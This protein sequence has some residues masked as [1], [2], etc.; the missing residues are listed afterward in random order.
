MVSVLRVKRIAD[1]IQEE[2]AEMLLHEVHDP[3]LA[4]V[5]VTSVN[6]DRELAF[7]DIFVSSLE[8][9][10]RA[11]EILAGFER[12]SGFLRKELSRRVELR[13]FPILRFHYDTTPEKAERIEQLLR[14]LH[15]SA[16]TPVN[17]ETQ[18]EKNTKEGADGQNGSE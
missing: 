15:E 3:R 5:T 13:T 12:A 2:L 10:Q 6:I 17:S 4:G 1:R 9:S 16:A 14:T 8:G 18:G 7:A 11:T